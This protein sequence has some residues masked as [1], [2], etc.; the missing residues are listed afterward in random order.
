MA[1]DGTPLKTCRSDAF[2]Q[3]RSGNNNLI[4]QLSAELR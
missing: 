4:V 3:N 2:V 1:P